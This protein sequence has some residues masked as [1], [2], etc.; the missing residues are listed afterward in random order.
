MKVSLL[1]SG[2][3]NGFTDDFVTCI[4]EYYLKDGVIVFIAS[5]FSR[6]SKTDRYTDVFLTMFRNKGIEFDEV[7]VID[8]RIMKEKARQYIEKSDIVWLSGG[9]TLQQIAYLKEYDLIPSL[10]KRE[11]MTIGMSAG[12]INMATRVV[13]AKDINDHIPELT[14]YD[15]IGLVEINIEPHLNAASE[16]HISDIHEA[17]RFAAIYGLYDNSFIKVV[18]NKMEI[19]G[20]CFKYENV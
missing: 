1:T 3:P 7:F 5:D 6:H 12:S 19:F 2:F 16:E 9:D 15:G 4:K 17:S 8:D 14:I 20:D 13:L 11:G 18:D 10:Q